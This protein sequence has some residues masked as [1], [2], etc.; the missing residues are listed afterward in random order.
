MVLN[1]TQ[2]SR[3]I[4]RRA[5][6]LSN[7]VVTLKTRGEFVKEIVRLCREATEKFLVIGR[8]LQNAK[9]ILAH[10]EYE[11]MIKNDLP[12][13]PEAARKIVLAAKAVDSGTLPRDRLPNSWSIVYLI[14]TLSEE[15]LDVAEKQGLIRPDVKRRD[16][17]AFKKS[18]VEAHISEYDRLL[19]ER[20]KLLTEAQR[21]QARLAE[22]DSKIGG[23]LIEGTAR[24][25]DD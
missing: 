22:I 17:V 5:E 1:F 3:A 25:I 6:D 24:E 11:A 4:D 19:T 16:I 21:I 7:T 20:E 18:R 10:G 23:E 8:Y 13:T 12:F 9:S 2:S 14:S 15:D